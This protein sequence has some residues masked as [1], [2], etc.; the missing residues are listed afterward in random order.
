MPLNE[1]NVSALPDEEV[2]RMFA[3]CF[4]TG[5]GRFVLSFLRKVT[6]ERCLGP[7]AS[8][9]ELRYLE[10]QRRLVKYIEALS[11]CKKSDF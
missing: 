11:G 10:G 1:Y 9:A 4:I 6:L 3:G 2:R 5:E 8:D 7:D